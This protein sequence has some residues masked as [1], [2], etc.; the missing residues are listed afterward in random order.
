MSLV[1]CQF[2]QDPRTPVFGCQGVGN[3]IDWGMGILGVRGFLLVAGCVLSGLAMAG[4]DHS[5][6]GALQG[7]CRQA[8]LSVDARVGIAVLLNGGG[9]PAAAVGAEEMYP[10]MSVV[11]LPLA[12][13]VMQGVA[14]GRWRLDQSFT[15]SERNL[16]PDTWSPLR[17][18]CPKGGAFTLRELLVFMVA[19]SDNNVCDY[20]F[21]LVG[22]PAVVE[23]E[24]VR[25]LGERGMHIRYDEEGLRDFSKISANAASPLALCRLLQ[26]LDEAALGKNPAG[27]TPRDAILPPAEAQQLL[28]VM[29]QTRTG[30]ACLAAGV[31]QGCR[32]EHKTGSGPMSPEGRLSA[33]NDVG[34]LRLPDGKRACI[35]VFVADAAETTEAVDAVMRRVAEAT[36]QALEQ[37]P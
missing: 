6:A 2:T 23:A 25:Y 4:V 16:K 8:A 5:G 29:A 37:M 7:A 21:E 30:A 1:I 20:L 19:Q 28:G 9:E 12:V 18:A 36:V 34:I 17:E 14:S 33:R 35:A 27:G 15:V 22:G 32:L 24:M 3:V 13:V 10:M 31:P 26:L 11:K